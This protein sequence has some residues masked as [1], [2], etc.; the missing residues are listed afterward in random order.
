MADVSVAV[1]TS[2]RL[3]RRQVARA[4]RAGGMRVSFLESADLAKSLEQSQHRLLVL[5]SDDE[6]A[7][8]A[9][10]QTHEKHAHLPIVLVSM[11]SDNGPILKLLENH[12][13][14]H[15]VAKHGA[16]RVAKVNA[17]R[18]LYSM[19]DERELRVT[20]E[21]A[22]SGDIFG[23][24]KYIGGW[25][26]AFHRRTI[27]AMTD[28]APFLDE[29]ERYLRNLEV[30]QPAVPEI[31]TVADELLINAMVHAPRNDKGEQLYEHLGPI[32]TLVLEPSQ[33]VSVVYGCD[34]QRL[35]ISVSDNFGG[36]SRRTLSQ[37]LRRGFEASLIPE[38]KPGG[39]G[40]GLT[41]SLRSIHQ[42][43]FN[44]HAQTRTE[45]IAGWFLRIQS[46]SEFKQ[47]SKS[48]NLFFLAEAA[49]P[50]KTLAARNESVYLRGR[51]DENFEFG[52]ALECNSI[53]VRD[54]TTVTSRGLVRW[55]SFVRS[56]KERGAEL[57]AV[58]ESLISQAVTVA[59]VLDG[60]TVRSA[61]VPFE[62]GACGFEER[63][64]LPPAAILTEPG[65]PCPE[66]AGEMSFA[67]IPSIYEAFQRVASGPPG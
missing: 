60:L 12:D 51:L 15:L 55:I 20:C 33:W 17:A 7:V 14:S 54:L 4:L 53:D 29:F 37:Y 35:M 46:G 47:V 63:R 9:A 18:P 67:G 30:P 58:P 3:T 48:L 26:V 49:P 28:K 34:G 38:Q 13:V 45:V 22:L 41:L 6:S 59:G 42:L 8:E 44:V 16:I 2:D 40:L 5:D 11:R 43:I 64:E 56:L 25:G 31:V 19:L 57:I 65:G 39:A 24:E 32:P 52:S 66:C 62:C 27:K 36:L 1:V 50:K 23:V 10:L 21:K 61:L